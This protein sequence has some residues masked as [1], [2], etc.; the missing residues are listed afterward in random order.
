MSINTRKIVDFALED[1]GKELRDA[2]YSEIHDRVSAHFEAHKQL[3]AQSFITQE[4]TLYEDEEEGD[5]DEDH[6]DA[7]E[8]EAQIKKMVK[9]KCLNKESVGGDEEWDEDEEEI[10]RA[11]V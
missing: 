4:E 1:N 11:H 8:D 10:G 3:L 7:E 9:K 6:E 5:E 2:L